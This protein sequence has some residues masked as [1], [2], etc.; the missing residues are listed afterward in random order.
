MIKIIMPETVTLIIPT[1][2]ILLLISYCI[3][4]ITLDIILYY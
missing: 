4:D 1:W 2:F 3:I